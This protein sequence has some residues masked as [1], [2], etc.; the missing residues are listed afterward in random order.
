M[1]NKK[2][3]QNKGGF[4]DQ[5]LL[6]IVIFISFIT[7]F[8]MAIDYGNLARI[9]GN[10]D[11]MGDYGA[12]MLALGKTTDEVA[13]GLNSM[14]SPYFGTINGGDIVCTTED[15]ENY[16]V[17]FQLTGGY[18]GTK[19]LEPRETI[20]AKRAVFNERGSF[21]LDCSLTLTY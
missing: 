7:F 8:F 18:M 17:I 21:L 9:K 5:I 1:E 19:I 2:N 15:S 14:K 4:I 10:L 16:Q 3:T 13:E 20:V 11:L 12:R 6:W